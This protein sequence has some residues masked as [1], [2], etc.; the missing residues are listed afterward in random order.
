M[1]D[2]ISGSTS[3]QALGPVCHAVINTNRF[4]A[5]LAAW[6]DFLGQRECFRDRLSE[7][8]ARHWHAAALTGA[9]QAWLMNELGEAWLCIIEDAEAE[10]VAPFTRRGWLA[11]EVC[12]Q[13]VDALFEELR[14]GPFE[15][16]GEPADLDVSPNVR[17]MQVQGPAGEIVYLT[18]VRA[19]V[20]GFELA[21]ARCAVD[22]L[23][24]PV[25]L[26]AD[27]A[28]ASRTWQAFA[29]I[30]TMQFDIRI[31][32]INRAWELPLER[33]HP[34]AVAQLGGG[35]LIEIDQLPGLRCQNHATGHL[36]SGIAMVG[37]EVRDLAD[38]AAREATG[39]L[40]EGPFAGRCAALIRGYDNE[41]IELIER[42]AEATAILRDQAMAASMQAPRPSQTSQ[43]FATAGV[44]S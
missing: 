36:R 11:L 34:V 39:E 16:L 18:E 41:L 37:I 25:A 20:P 40:R 31:T 32:V 12:V 38:L 14:E 24:I 9:R 17:A 22:R 13:N 42:R 21:R 33:R 26:S 15:I 2:R 30:R 19:E 6:R 27:R 23:F 8:Q 35:S 28:S 43:P 1:S 5:T 44:A 4:D 7:R 3:E 29:G 10:P